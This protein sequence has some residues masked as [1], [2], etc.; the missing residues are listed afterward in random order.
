MS[1]ASG[2]RPVH[3]DAPLPPA[4]LLP[5][6]PPFLPVLTSFPQPGSYTLRTRDPV[7]RSRPEPSAQMRKLRPGQGEFLAQRL[8]DMTELSPNLGLCLQSP[9]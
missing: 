5:P 1:V 9:P 4:S 7:K 6:L 3:L 2:G 8:R